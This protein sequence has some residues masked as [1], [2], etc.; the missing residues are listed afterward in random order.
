MWLPVERA[1]PAGPPVSAFVAPGQTATSPP[2]ARRLAGQRAFSLIRRV[3]AAQPRW[4]ADSRTASAPAAARSAVAPHGARRRSQRRPHK[5]SSRCT[6]PT[7]GSTRRASIRAIIDC[8]TPARLA[9]SRWL[10]RAIRR[11][12]RRAATTSS[13]PISRAPADRCRP[14]T[15]TLTPSANPLTE[16]MSWPFLACGTVQCSSTCRCSSR[17]RLGRWRGIGDHSVLLGQRQ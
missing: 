8:D 7:G 9:R 16:P 11:P 15:L 1:H 6:R 10:S 2:V 14:L 17:R 5:P 13:P 3:A 4:R 12:W